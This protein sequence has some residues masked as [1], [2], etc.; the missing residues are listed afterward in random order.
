[1]GGEVGGPGLPKGDCKTKGP[2]TDQPDL[3]CW[4]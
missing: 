1:M 2:G 4:S 3:S